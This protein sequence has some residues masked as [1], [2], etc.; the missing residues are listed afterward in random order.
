MLYAI[1][2]RPLVAQHRLFTAVLYALCDRFSPWLPSTV[3]LRRCFM[4]YAIV[5]RPLVA[6]HRL[7]TAVLSYTQGIQS[8]IAKGGER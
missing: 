2:F 6:Q 7:F 4:L 3:C 5:F 1:V 8:Q